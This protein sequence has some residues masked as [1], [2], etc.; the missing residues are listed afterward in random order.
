MI[1]NFQSFLLC[2][3]YMEGG[4]L[5][6]YFRWMRGYWFKQFFEVRR[7]LF[8][9]I[10]DIVVDFGFVLGVLLLNIMFCALYLFVCQSWC[11][12]SF[13]RVFYLFLVGVCQVYL[14]RRRI[15]IILIFLQCGVGLY[16]VQGDIFFVFT[17]Y[18]VW[19]L[20]LFWFDVYCSR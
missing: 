19:W 13:T 14:I 9:V 12:F 15:V 11:L 8:I 2:F 17:G 5:Y 3:G 7:I 1:E 4:V 20:L 10:D 16:L 18:L 6:F